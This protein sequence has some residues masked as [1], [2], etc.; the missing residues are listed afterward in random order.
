MSPQRGASP[1]CLPLT[2]TSLLPPV[3]PGLP[4]RQNNAHWRPALDVHV[5]GLRSS[6]CHNQIEKKLK[7]F[8]NHEYIS[9]PCFRSS[10]SFSYDFQL[11]PTRE[12]QDSVK[13][14]S[15]TRRAVGYFCPVDPNS[16]TQKAGIWLGSEV[17]AQTFVCATRDGCLPVWPQR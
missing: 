3:A 13:L 7:A 12:N 2:A 15:K 16:P 8:L 9:Y 1:L 11:F 5:E 10:F 6:V 4:Y 17:V 14:S